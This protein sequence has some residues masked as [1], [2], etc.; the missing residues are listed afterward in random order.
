MRTMKTL[1]LISVMLSITTSDDSV[2][3][4]HLRKKYQNLNRQAYNYQNQ[5]KDSLTD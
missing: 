3:P 2:H 5:N 1:T 4:N